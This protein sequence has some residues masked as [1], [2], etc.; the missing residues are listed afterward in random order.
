MIFSEQRDILAL[1]P[2]PEDQVAILAF[3]KTGQFLRFM[4]Q[5]GIHGDNIAVALQ[6]A[7]LHAVLQVW[8]IWVFWAWVR[9]AHC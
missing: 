8:G 5:A 1:G 3:Q 2:H 7:V 9:Q 6:Y 4:G